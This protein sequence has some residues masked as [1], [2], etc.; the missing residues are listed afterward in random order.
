MPGLRHPLAGVPLQHQRLQARSE[1]PKVLVQQNQ[2][3]L[4]F[5]GR[6]RLLP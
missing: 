2:Q 3:P 5:F 4:E 1:G 6:R